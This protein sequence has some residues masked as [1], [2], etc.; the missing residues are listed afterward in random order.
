MYNKLLFYNDENLKSIELIFTKREFD[1]LKNNLEWIFDSDSS[2]IKPKNDSLDQISFSYLL[3]IFP[4]IEEIGFENF[5][6]V[7]FDD[8]CLNPFTLYAEFWKHNVGLEIGPITSA[9]GIFLTPKEG[10]QRIERKFSVSKNKLLEYSLWYDEYGLYGIFKTDINLFS[11]FYHPINGLFMMKNESEFSSLQKKIEKFKNIKMKK[12]SNDKRLFL[13]VISVY[14]L[15][16]S[17]LKYRILN[18]NFSIFPLINYITPYKGDEL[19]I[20]SYEIDSVISEDYL[21]YTNEGIDFD[22]AKNRYFFETIIADEFI[23]NYNDLI[24]GLE[25]EE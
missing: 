20:K 7:S 19:L 4:S 3:K 17:E 12:Y 14:D 11:G 8:S 6:Y 21:I 5:N 22:F 25:Y 1:T 24:N 2:V 23:Y 18:N 13:R 9:D 15:S 10:R 16:T